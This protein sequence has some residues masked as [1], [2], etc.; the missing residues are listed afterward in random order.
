MKTW[1]SPAS[2]RMSFLLSRAEAPETVIEPEPQVTLVLRRSNR[3][4]AP[5]APVTVTSALVPLSLLLMMN[6]PPLMT[7][8]VLTPPA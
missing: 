4:V 2:E 3:A 7:K 1:P 8:E 5:L 6:E